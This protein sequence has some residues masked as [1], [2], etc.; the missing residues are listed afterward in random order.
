MLEKSPQ[1]LAA[2]DYDNTVVYGPPSIMAFIQQNKKPKDVDI[3]GEY[4]IR[5]AGTLGILGI[6]L[7][8]IPNLPFIRRIKNDAWI[9]FS[10]LDREEQSDNV[11]I[12]RAIISGRRIG[13][14][15]AVRWTAKAIPNFN[16]YLNSGISSHIYKKR[17]LY[18]LIKQKEVEGEKV[19]AAFFNDDWR[20][21]FH[22]CQLNDMFNEQKSESVVY[23][24]VVASITNANLSDD[25]KKEMERRKIKIVKNLSDAVADYSKIV[26]QSAIKI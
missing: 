11:K 6:A 22:I 7:A 10:I 15:W 13:T 1:F 2:F 20:A 8:Q 3:S 18:G 25:I 23:G 19:V 9:A 12:D 17:K 26:H 4:K 5:G 14:H 21:V 24:Y 16:L